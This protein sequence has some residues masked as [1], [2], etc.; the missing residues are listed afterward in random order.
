MST[1]VFLQ[2]SNLKEVAVMPLKKGTASI[3]RLVDEGW[4]KFSYQSLIRRDVTSKTRSV[5]CNTSV[6]NSIEEE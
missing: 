6:E 3:A 5:N 4:H 2:N 1:L